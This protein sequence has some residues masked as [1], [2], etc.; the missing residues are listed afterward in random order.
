MLAVLG[1]ARGLRGEIFANPVGTDPE[2]F[3]PGLAV[4]L[5]SPA[6]EK[7]EAQVERS[8][9]HNGR[10]VLKFEGIKNRSDAEAIERFEVRIPIEQR[11][12]A[13]EGRYYLGDLVG[14]SVETVDG[15]KLGQVAE[16]H[17]FGASALLEVQGEKEILIPWVP[18]ICLQVDSEARRILV[19]LPEGLEDLN[20]R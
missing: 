5:F 15:R 1:Q 13:P 4:S 16:W 7:T 18:S 17:D 10:L 2:R 3:E 20:A 14:Y 8:W 6:G 11:P 19:E 9:M 12:P